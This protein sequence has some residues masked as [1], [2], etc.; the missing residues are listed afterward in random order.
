MVEYEK[1]R[2]LFVEDDVNYCNTITDVLLDEGYEVDTA[3]AALQGMELLALNEYDLIISDLFMGNVDGI[4]FLRYVKRVKPMV[5]TMILT[6]NPT[7]DTELEALNLNVDK[8]AV[9][10]TRIDVLL[11]YIEL[12]LRDQDVTNN[13]RYRTLKDTNEDVV[14][15]LRSR[16]VSKDGQVVEITP[17]EFQIIVYLLEHMGEAVSR[18]ELLEK[19]WDARYED[20]DIRV[21]DVHIKDI[22]K[23]LQVQSIVSVR[24]FGYRWDA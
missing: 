7:M 3:E 20:I 19:L 5:K 8:Y 21:I 9:K 6:A 14:V 22:R 1:K 10:E 18:D 24:G 12:L 13:R 17:K 16:T 2:I 23:K 11:K 15:D 4:E